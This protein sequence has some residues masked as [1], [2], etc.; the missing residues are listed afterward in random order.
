MRSCSHHEDKL[1]C[2]YLPRVVIYFQVCTIMHIPI[3]AVGNDGYG[4]VV[5]CS[6]REVHPTEHSFLSDLKSHTED[7]KIWRPQNNACSQQPRMAFSL[8]V[9]IHP[10]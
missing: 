1:H 9:F 2:I 3:A 7:K 5:K 8:S 4:K 6:G 10:Y